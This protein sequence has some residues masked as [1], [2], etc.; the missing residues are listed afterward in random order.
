MSN[1]Y[2]E[3]V[4]IGGGVPSIRLDLAPEVRTMRVLY[5]VL[6]IMYNTTFSDQEYPIWPR[7]AYHREMWKAWVR[8]Y[9]LST[10]DT[11][12]ANCSECRQ[13]WVL[14]C[15]RT[16]GCWNIH[17]SLVP[18]LSANWGL[19]SSV[20]RKAGYEATST[21]YLS[22]WKQGERACPYRVKLLW[23]QLQYSNFCA[24]TSSR[25]SPSTA[26]IALRHQTRHTVRKWSSV[27]SG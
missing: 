25:M 21:G 20:C 4:T 23:L 3:K 15:H 2:Y 19:V 12:H 24:I 8:G 16:K 27:R 14:S 26:L 6:T 22:E 18:R 10:S 17:S 9:V 13:S 1:N 5:I 7:K 11:T